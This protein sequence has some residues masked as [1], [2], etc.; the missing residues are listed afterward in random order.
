MVFHSPVRLS[1][2]L[3]PSLVFISPPVDSRDELFELF[4]TAFFKAGRVA[5]PDHVVRC[6]NHRESILTTAIGGGVAIPHA[7]IQGL[8]RLAM[9]ASI[10]PNGIE[11]PALDDI[12]VRLVFCLL[13][14]TDTQADHLAGLAH[15]ARL[16][17]TDGAL[18]A[19]IRADSS[20]IFIET[21]NRIETD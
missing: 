10:H 9:A 18:A 16:A 17:R 11:Y 5:D 7:Q 20:T 13:G 21:L 2:H 6:L 19:L 15:L 12:T 4:G 8:G 1:Q 14:G 3:S